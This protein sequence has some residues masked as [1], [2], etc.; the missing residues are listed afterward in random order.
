MRQHCK[1]NYTFELDEY[2]KYALEITVGNAVV[3]LLF[4]ESLK[5]TSQIQKIITYFGIDELF[6]CITF[7]AYNGEFHR[8]FDHQGKTILEAIK[9]K[10]SPEI[11]SL[12]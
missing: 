3:T 4:S 10:I 2:S 11:Y 9:H 12:L 6:F 1:D 5:S 8:R 7:V